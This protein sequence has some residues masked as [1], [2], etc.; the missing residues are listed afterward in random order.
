MKI[1]Q[2]KIVISYTNRAEKIFSSLIINKKILKI[3]F[4]S[5]FH[6]KNYRKNFGSEEKIPKKID[7]AI[8]NG[9][10]KS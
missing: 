8:P 3:F 6:T 1:S 9:H 7:F 2:F 5:F 10:S 4:L